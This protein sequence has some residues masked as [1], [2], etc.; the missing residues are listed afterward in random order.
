MKLIKVLFFCLVLKL[1]IIFPVQI[2]AAEILQIRSS[3]LIQVGDQNRTYSVS[4]A[5]INVLPENEANVIS[6]LRTELP[7]RTKVNLKP[8]GL[9]DGKIVA[10]LIILE[11]GRDISLSLVDARLADLTC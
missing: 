11:D 2:Q 9:E 1:I 8:K 3:S 10:N 7:R 5:C 6:F 4:L